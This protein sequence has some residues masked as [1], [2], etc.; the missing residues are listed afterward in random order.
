MKTTTCGTIEQLVS[1]Y[2]EQKESNCR[3]RLEHGSGCEGIQINTHFDLPEARDETCEVL[4][5]DTP[6]SGVDVQIGSSAGTLCLEHLLVWL[7]QG[8]TVE[9]DKC[10][11]WF[12]GSEVEE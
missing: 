6:Y 8:A 3:F 2:A 12:E 4:G 11:A 1:D 7:D 9:C 10:A 5:C